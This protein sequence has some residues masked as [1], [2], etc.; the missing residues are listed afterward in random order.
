MDYER[1]LNNQQKHRSDIADIT[2]AITNINN[3]QI[4]QEESIVNILDKLNQ[5]I[6]SNDCEISN[7]KKTIDGNGQL[8]LKTKTALLEKGQKEVE[9]EFKNHLAGH[10]KFAV[11]I[12]SITSLFSGVVFEII[13][14]S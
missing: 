4:R 1:R 10:W 3:S 14:L 5:Y 11:L 13:K 8:G 2:V 12:I 9:K 7:F 6:V